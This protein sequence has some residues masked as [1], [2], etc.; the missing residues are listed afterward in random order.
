MALISDGAVD[1]ADVRNA[2]TEVSYRGWAVVEVA[3]R[4]RERLAEVLARVNRVLGKSDGMPTDH[5]AGA[6]TNI[7]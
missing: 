6:T 3:G 5:L 4:D 7:G 2:L 1:W